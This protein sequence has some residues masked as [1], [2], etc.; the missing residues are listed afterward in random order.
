R[1]AYAGVAVRYWGLVFPQVRRELTRWRSQALAVPDPTLRQHALESLNAKRA[2]V[3][4]SALFAATS[5][6]LRLEVIRFVTAYQI[7]FDYVDTVSESAKGLK[8]SQLLHHS[9]L[10]AVDP[11]APIVDHYG[12][13][14][15]QDD[16]GYLAELV[17]ACRRWS[18]SLPSY[19]T[20]RPRVTHLTELVYE[21]QSRHNTGGREA[22]AQL[23]QWAAEQ[24]WLPA[25]LEWWEVCC[26]ASSTLAVCAL[27]SSAA[28]AS[29]TDESL[30]QLETAYLPWICA[31]NVL[32]D[33]VV[34]QQEDV[35]AR[36]LNYTDQYR[37]PEEATERL[38][39][40]AARAMESARRLPDPALHVVVVSGIVG[41]YASHSGVRRQGLEP[42]MRRLVRTVGPLGRL[43][44][45]IFKLKRAAQAVGRRRRPE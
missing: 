22:A 16:G 36:Q 37:S 45:W 18:A 13:H 27:V 8:Q 44:C 32:L 40:V 31:L 11:A 10:E 23:K 20:V 14:H 4:G 38:D 42:V 9:L 5:R 26:A 30:E 17:G 15:N 34:D 41:L 12:D 1:A 28:G 25:E 3:E 24:T 7:I 6:T 39:L 35:T 33:S 2:H 19:E 21:V 43:I 29:R